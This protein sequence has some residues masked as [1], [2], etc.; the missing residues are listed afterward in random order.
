MG[1]TKS[2]RF[3]VVCALLPCPLFSFAPTE[4]MPAA[5]TRFVLDNG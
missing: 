1:N 5:R 2:S 4:A 3:F